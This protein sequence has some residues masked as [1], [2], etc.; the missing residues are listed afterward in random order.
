MQ[1]GVVRMPSSNEG[2]TTHVWKCPR[3]RLVE[4]LAASVVIGATVV[5]VIMGLKAR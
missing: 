1:P 3:P 2:P 4:L 5:A